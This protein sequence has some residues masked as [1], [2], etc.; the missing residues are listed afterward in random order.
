MNARVEWWLTPSRGTEAIKKDWL[1][2]CVRVAAMVGYNRLVGHVSFVSVLLFVLPILVKAL[3]SN[4]Y[5]ERSS[6]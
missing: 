5:G 2:W 3:V 6:F 4:A 1:L